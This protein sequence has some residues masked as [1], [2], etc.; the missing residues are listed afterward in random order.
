MKTLEHLSQDGI[1]PKK[2]DMD[3]RRR[4]LWTIQPHWHDFY[5]IEIC[6]EGYGKATVNGIEYDISPGTIQFFTPSDFHS[7]SSIPG[8]SMSVIN[9][10]FKSSCVESLSFG[11]V[12]TSMGYMVCNPDTEQTKH[13]VYLI[14]TI[15][16]E[17]NKETYFSKKYS[18]HLL[19]CILIE[20]FRIYKNSDFSSV[21]SHQQDSHMQKILYYIRTHF[22]ESVTLEDLAEYTD[23]SIGYISKLFK[24]NLGC[25]FKQFLIEL[26]LLHAENLLTYSDESISNIAYFCGFTSASH[27]MNM[28]K[29]KYHTSPRNYRKIYKH[30]DKL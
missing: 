17:L 6:L 30:R 19:I 4:V 12:L 20:L 13:I 21:N 22:K 9:F 15:E 28:F 10:T 8:N 3:I 7:Y 14:E 11:D 24:K 23:L 25:G 26:R 29:K 5:E 1:L 2:F 16:K 18:I 27:F